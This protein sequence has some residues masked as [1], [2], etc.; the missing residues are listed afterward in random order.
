MAALSAASAHTTNGLIDPSK[1]GEYPIL[2]GDRLAGKQ[3]AKDSRLINV[4]FNYKPKGASPQQRTVITRGEAEDLYNLTIRDEAGNA[5][6]TTLTYK[7]QGSVDPGLPAAETEYNGLALVFDPR[8]KAFI[9]E[10]VS[11][12][13]NFNL[14]SGPGKDQ[15]TRDRYPQLKTLLDEAQAA[16]AKGDDEDS[17]NE[18]VGPADESNPFDFRHF[19]PKSEAE[20]DKAGGKSPLGTSSELDRFPVKPKTS[21]LAPATA[22]AAGPKSGLKPLNKPRPAKPKTNPLRL[23]KRAP[24]S[25]PAKASPAPSKAKPTASPP[26]VEP[27]R[28]IAPVESSPGEDEQRKPEPPAAPS[29]NIIVDGDLIIDMGSPPPQR[30]PFKIN[31]RHFSSNNTSGNEAGFDSDDDDDLQDPQL[32]VALTR[33]KFS[34]Q[35]EEEE[36][37][38]EDEEE[39]D[40]VEDEVMNDAP[41]I[42]QQTGSAPEEDEIDDNDDPIAAELK[43][44]FEQTRLEEEQRARQ[45]H[46]QRRQHVVSDDE[47]E[48]S[49]EE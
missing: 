27:E 47:S 41:A 49:E 25:T 42:Q 39:D 34:R 48:V 9:L 44:A 22:T 21:H 45:L 5:E 43:A 1:P 7:Y 24:T 17:A 2:L 8:R 20:T 46:Y 4:N 31:P 12:S 30:R 16:K 14:R 11:T 29:P 15:N 3:S 10:P 28:E 18:D 38:D 33:R 40:E 6:K 23:Q 36:E 32:P 35:P 37:S 19:L 13:L 26:R